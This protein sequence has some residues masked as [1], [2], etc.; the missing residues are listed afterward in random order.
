MKRTLTLGALWTA[1]AATAVGLGFLAV[2]LVDASASPPDLTAASSTNSPVTTAPTAA[3]AATS[4]HGADDPAAPGPSAPLASVQQVT[5]GGTVYAGCTDGQPVLAGAPVAGW[6]VDDS[7]APDRVEFSDG[8][9][10]IEVRVDC[11]TG[12]PQFS[13]E[14]PRAGSRGGADDKSTT[15]PAV[16][17]ANS[18]ATTTRDDSTGRAGGG[19][20]SDDGAADDS[21][22]RGSGGHGSD[23]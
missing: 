15:A 6:G 2:S 19:H 22:G 8:V 11:S 9:Q 12:T 18:P 17:T 13:V 23:D 14:G 1:S 4:S 7:S 5:A 20:G 21:S 10:S 3:A 16:S